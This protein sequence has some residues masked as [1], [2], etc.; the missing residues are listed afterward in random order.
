MTGLHTDVVGP[1]RPRFAF[2]H[3]LLGRGRNWTGIAQSLGEA[4]HAS[5]LF[6]LPNHGRSHWTEIFDYRAMAEEVTAEIGLRLGSAAS[7]ILVGHSMGGK[8]AMLAA[9]GRPALAEALAVIDIAPGVSERVHSFDDLLDALRSVDLASV[10]SRTD[11]DRMLAERIPDTSVRLFLLQN[12]RRRPHWHWQPNLD[13]LAASLPQIAGWPDPGA[14][15]YPGPVRWITG[16]RSPYVTPAD[17]PVMSRLFPRTRRVV[18]PA[19][20]HWV[21]SDDPDAV[22]AALLDLADEVEHDRGP[23]RRRPRQH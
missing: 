21:H 10:H 9:L 15:S 11:A 6:D 20:G 14:V 3:G 23:R 18:V 8:V 19:A 1:G 5:V 2:L 12:L 17:E 16:E 13:L 4:G 7:M 22:V